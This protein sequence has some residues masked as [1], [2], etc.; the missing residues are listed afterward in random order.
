M[1]RRSGARSPGR[2]SGPSFSRL[3][4]LSTPAAAYRAQA[5]AL[6]IES[7]AKRRLADEYDAAQERGEVQA[8]GGNRGNQHVAIIPDGKNAATVSDIG[9]SSKQ[10]HEARQIR[11]AE[12]REPGIVKRAVDERVAAGQEPTRAAVRR[13]IVPDATVGRRYAGPMSRCRVLPCAAF[14]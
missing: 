9:L 11:D 1:P 10:I 14:R 4:K 3:E 6:L 13:A 7:Q 12:E 5:D 8:A 2:D